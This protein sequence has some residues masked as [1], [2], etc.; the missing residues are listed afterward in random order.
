[1][2]ELAKKQVDEQAEAARKEREARRQR[3]ITEEEERMK[4][5]HEAFAAELR[6]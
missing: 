4:R 2:Q 5:E 1:M 3:L 6:R